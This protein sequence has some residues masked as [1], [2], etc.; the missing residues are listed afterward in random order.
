M[1]E[2]SSRQG[3]AMVTRRSV[4]VHALAVGETTVSWR[5]IFPLSFA[6]CVLHVRVACPCRCL[7]AYCVDD[8]THAKSM[9]NTMHEDF[10]L[11]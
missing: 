4:D 9:E 5:I 6:C 3:R 10:Y 8:E 1:G 11:T 7:V 2:A